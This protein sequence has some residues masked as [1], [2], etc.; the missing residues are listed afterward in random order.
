LRS[1]FRRYREAISCRE[2]NVGDGYRQQT[3][4]SMANL[5]VRKANFEQALFD[6]ASVFELLGDLVGHPSL[7]LSTRRNPARLG[8]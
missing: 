5:P 7:A 6:T 3:E 4:E 1:R 2:G 8:I